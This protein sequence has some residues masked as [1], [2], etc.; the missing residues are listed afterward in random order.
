MIFRGWHLG[1]TSF[2]LGWILSSVA[3][4]KLLG[5]RDL[6]LGSLSCT[7]IS[8]TSFLRLILR[9]LLKGARVRYGCQILLWLTNLF[10]NR[11]F[12]GILNWKFIGLSSCS[13][14]AEIRL[15]QLCRIVRSLNPLSLNQLPSVL[16]NRIW[17][18]CNFL[19]VPGRVA[20]SLHAGLGSFC[21]THAVLMIL[22]ASGINHGLTRP[23]LVL[24]ETLIKG[25]IIDLLDNQ[26]VRI[27]VCDKHRR[28]WLG[29]VLILDTSIYT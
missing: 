25:V 23:E 15:F 12:H 21:Y 2:N 22:S 1:S 9:L 19:L 13:R 26:G 11:L 8:S 14:L 20:L 16:L 7:W 17:G 4:L 10:S 29:A 24:K 18:G 28:K 27:V 6:W 5:L 3:H